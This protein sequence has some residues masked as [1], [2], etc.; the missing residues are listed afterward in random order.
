M[1]ALVRAGVP[2][3]LFIKDPTPED[4]ARFPGVEVAGLAGMSRTWT[5]AQMQSDLR[6]R[7]ECLRALAPRVCHYKVCST[8]DSSPTIGS[9]GAAIDI[10]QSLFES[11]WVPLVIG[12]PRLRRY[13]LFGNLFAGFGPEV[14]RLDRHPTMS[15]HPVT[16]MAEA[17]LRAHLAQQ[18]RRAI[19]LVD[20]LALT[21]DAQQ[22]DERLQA[23][24]SGAGRG[25]RP[26]IVLF[27]VLDEDRLASVGRLVWSGAQR[28][29][30]TLFCAGSSGLEYALVGHWQR[31]GELPVDP[32]GLPWPK[33]VDQILAVSGSC[34][35]Q[36]ASQIEHALANGFVGIDVNAPALLDPATNGAARSKAVEA[37]LGALAAGQSV[38]LYSARGPGDPRIRELQ[39]ASAARHGDPLAFGHALGGELGAVL[40]TIVERRRVPRVALA[41][42]DTSG[43]LAKAMG[44]EIL[45]PVYQSAPGSVLCR[46]HSQHDFVQGV[47]LVMKGGQVGNE[48]F[49][50]SVKTGVF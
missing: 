37:T 25:D 46:V 49:F 28:L 6:P 30:R 13:T 17:D 39:Q 42:G 45:E 4:L 9:I 24:L 40:R 23:L 43:H 16:P 8:F 26:E 12:A 7:L 15:R 5:P 31:T 41:G 1:D 19:G 21:G 33:P 47:E 22:V 32:P 20:I 38:L 48:R 27:D 18:T 10:G 44:V 50:V 3:V 29:E 2:T 14:F 35:P 34:S 11:P 36:T